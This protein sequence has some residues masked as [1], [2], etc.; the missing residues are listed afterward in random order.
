MGELNPRDKTECAV[1]FSLQAAYSRY[2]YVFHP[3]MQHEKDWL[4]GGGGQTAAA[5]LSMSGLGDYSES[6]NEYIKRRLQEDGL[7]TDRLSAKEVE[8]FLQYL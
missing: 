4:F 2:P 6:L 1:L 5:Q 8:Q 7:Q 3:D